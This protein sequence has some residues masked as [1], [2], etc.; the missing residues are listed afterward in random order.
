MREK[1]DDG[2]A[3]DVSPFPKT[4]DGDY[5]LPKFTDE[6]DYC[7]AK[8]ESWIWSIGQSEAPGY[9]KMPD[10]TE[11]MLPSGSIVASTTQKFYQAE[12]NG[13]KCLWLR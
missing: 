5:I 12:T 3:I 11:R 8:T 13:W 1:L 4:A 10:G 7:D 6:V 2:R 9:V